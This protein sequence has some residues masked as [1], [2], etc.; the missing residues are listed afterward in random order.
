ML[1]NCYTYFFMVDYA[2]TYCTCSNMYDIVKCGRS[3]I[4]ENIDHS[5]LSPKAITIKVSH[6]HI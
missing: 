4:Y 3:E 1:V 5:T 2:S 6:T